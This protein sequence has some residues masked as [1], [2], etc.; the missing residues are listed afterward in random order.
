MN[1]PPSLRHSPSGLLERIAWFCTGSDVR[2]MEASP[3]SDRIK[4]QGLGW[5][6]VTSVGITML[7]SAGLTVL[8]LKE[9]S[10]PWSIA[11]C[12]SL[13]AGLI[14]LLF[15]RWSLQFIGHGDGTSKI[16]LSE[17]RRAIPLFV[18][19]LTL[20]S[21]LSVPVEMRV[22]QSEIQ[23]L[24]HKDSILLQQQVSRTVHGDY[25]QK[26]DTIRT[27]IA[28]IQR[29]LKTLTKDQE[30]LR[31]ELVHIQQSSADSSN[32]ERIHQLETQF[33]HSK[34]SYH[35]KRTVKESQIQ[36]YKTQLHTLRQQER[37]DIAVVIE[38]SKPSSFWYTLS[39]LGQT[40]VV[41]RFFVRS[42]V[43]LLISSPILF[44][45]M[46]SESFFSIYRKQPPLKQDTLKGDFL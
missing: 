39:L 38:E 22:V 44:G 24:E 6:I 41:I 33:Q 21:I 19:C 3:L 32:N 29:E 4:Y 2:L 43:V 26:E 1:L 9:P 14:T 20:G 36:E 30:Q 16:T 31:S 46:L 28:K 25:K 15:Y 18:C 45:M 10:I 11:L 5:S 7:M 27:E 8:I 34:E 17:L 42:I 37:L 12:V 13:F 23:I 35:R 40:D